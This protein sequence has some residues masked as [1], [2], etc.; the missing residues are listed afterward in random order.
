MSGR[1]EFV[2]VRH[3]ENATEEK[4]RIMLHKIEEFLHA[5]YDLLEATGGPPNKY[6]PLEIVTEGL[7]AVEHLWWRSL[8]DDG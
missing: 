7:D 4:H 3:H 1:K 6:R 2:P 5:Y 8:D